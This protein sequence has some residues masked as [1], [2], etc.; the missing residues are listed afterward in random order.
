MGSTA[1][2]TTVFIVRAAFDL[3]LVLG[4]LGLPFLLIG[5]LGA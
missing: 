1:I 3:A 4:G 2:V 5:L